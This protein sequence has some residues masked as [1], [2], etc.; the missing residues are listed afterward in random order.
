MKP[1]KLYF[2]ERGRKKKI[3]VYARTLASAKKT[4]SNLYYVDPS[5]LIAV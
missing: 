4:A 2:K 5:K 1:F 3:C